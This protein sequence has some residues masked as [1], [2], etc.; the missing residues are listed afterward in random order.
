MGE[1]GNTQSFVVPESNLVFI[2]DAMGRH[3]QSFCRGVANTA[4]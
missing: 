4:V 1:T 3:G 2:P